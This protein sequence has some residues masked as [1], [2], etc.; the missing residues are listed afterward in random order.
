MDC[1]DS[2]EYV[3]DVNKGSRL[4]PDTGI[5]SLPLRDWCPLRVYSLSPSAPGARG[6]GGKDGTYEVPQRAPHLAKPVLRPPLGCRQGFQQGI[7]APPG[8]TSVRHLAVA[9]ATRAG[10]GGARVGAS[11]PP[12]E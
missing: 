5:F 1:A 10:G 8:A 12:S 3:T 2:E 4:V 11:S 9:G 7:P 6:G